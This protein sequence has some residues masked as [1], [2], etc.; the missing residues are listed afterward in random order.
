MKNVAKIES[1]AE[2]RIYHATCTCLVYILVRMVLD[3]AL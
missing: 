3:C 1:Q 2:M